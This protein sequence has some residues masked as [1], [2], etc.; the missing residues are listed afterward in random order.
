MKI[1][2]AGME[3]GFEELISALALGSKEHLALVGGGGKTTLMFTLAEALR[4]E[5]RRVVTGT[6]TKVRLPESLHALKSVFL[7]SDPDWERSLRTGLDTHGHVF[8]CNEIL[9]SGKVTGITKSLADTLWKNPWIDHL[10]LEADG[11]AG[12][13]VKA[14]ESHEP[15][16]PDSVTMV[17]AVVGLDA[18]GAP[19]DEEHVFRM[20][21]F[22]KITGLKPGEDITPGGLSRVFEGRE[23]LFKGTPPMARRVVFLNKLDVVQDDR[24][25]RLLR[26]YILD[27]PEAGVNMV[28]TGSLRLRKLERPG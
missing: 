19:F 27:S 3:K 22:E 10:I 15:V 7:S 28:I 26:E 4:K 11:A 2:A 25:V 14:P 18:L 5:G 21:R 24:D 12:R 16:I 9:P 1:P 17:I 6:T 23:G 8:F 13:P 20:D